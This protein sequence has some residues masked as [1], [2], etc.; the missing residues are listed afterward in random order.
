MTNDPFPLEQFLRA[1][2]AVLTAIEEFDISQLVPYI[3]QSNVTKIVSS[4]L[5]GKKENLP[6]AVEN[7]ID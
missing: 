2:A 4:L 3:T 5:T 7:A 6:K 1:N